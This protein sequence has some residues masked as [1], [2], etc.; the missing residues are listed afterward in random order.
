MK[1]NQNIKNNNKNKN[2]TEVN[3]TWIKHGVMNFIKQIKKSKLMKI[4]LIIVTSII[5][6]IS[7]KSLLYTL[8]KINIHFYCDMQYKAFKW[9]YW[10]EMFARFNIFLSVCWEI[11]K[12]LWEHSWW[13]PAPS[14]IKKVL[15]YLFKFC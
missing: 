8:E 4:E 13:S 15:V 3:N 2:F 7:H 12:R 9:K 10:K 1:N 5:W 11:S 6:K 14:K